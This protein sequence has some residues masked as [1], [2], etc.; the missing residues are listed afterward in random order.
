LT[1]GER[2]QYNFTDPQ[3]RIMKNPGN[4]GFDQHYNG[5]M[6][7]DHQTLLIVANTLSNHPNDQLDALPTVDR[8]DIRV[9]KVKRAALDTGYFSATNIEGLQARQIDPF[10]ATGRQPHRIYWQT[11][12][13]QLPA[14]PTE[15]APLTSKMAHKLQTVEGKAFYRLRKCTVEPVIGIIKETM[16]FR[17]FSLRGLTK[18]AGEWNL[19]CLAFNCKRLHRLLGEKTISPTSC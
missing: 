3:S 2:E 17:Q 15:L 13:A 9:G 18:A 19:V 12:L 10:I 8:I 4:K 6:A 7:V 14:P 11:L 5:Q 1:I 16:G